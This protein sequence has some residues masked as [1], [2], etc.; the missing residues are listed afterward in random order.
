MLVN[1]NEWV[2]ASL[3]RVS[4]R[5]HAQR[6]REGS[7]CHHVSCFALK[8]NEPCSHSRQWRT[9]IV[10]RDYKEYHTD[11]T[12]RFI[13]KM[14]AEN[15]RKAEDEGLHKCES[16]IRIQLNVI[17][18]NPFFFEDTS[19][20]RRPSRPPQ[21][22]SS[23]VKMSCVASKTSWKYY[24]S[25]STLVLSCTEVERCNLSA[26]EQLSVHLHWS[27]VASLFSGVLGRSSCRRVAC[28]RQ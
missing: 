2:D 9:L 16:P 17:H 5:T 3:Q 19:R 12:V 4:P 28:A 6:K 18:L 27:E 24:A 21:W 25:F 23:I 20:S 7:C 8:A 14:T 11:T 10:F 22:S 26:P 15:L 1:R 13:V